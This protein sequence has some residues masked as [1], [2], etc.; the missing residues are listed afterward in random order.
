MTAD[1]LIDGTGCERDLARAVR[2][3]SLAAE[4]GHRMARQYLRE[5]LDEDA[6]EW[7]GG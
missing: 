1:C 6:E 2:L 7:R 4:Q 5:W 3:L